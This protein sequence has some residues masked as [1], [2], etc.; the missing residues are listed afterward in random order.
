MRKDGTKVKG[1]D[2]MHKIM[3]HLM[4]NRCDAEVCT[5][6]SFDV[7]KL[8]KYI[9]DKN[10]Q[11]DYKITPFHTIITAL[12][13]TIYNR[14]LL[15]RFIA[16]KHYYD[17]NDVTFS[18]VAK[19]KFADNAEERLLILKVNEGMNLDD[20]SSKIYKDVSKTRKE[21]T[22]DMDHTLDIVTNGPRFIT[23]FIMWAFR[24]MDFYGLIPTSI[25]S[26]D[27]NYT[28]VLI[29]NLGSIKAPACYHHLNNYGTNSI[30]VTVGE[31]HK[32]YLLDKNGKAK[33][34]DMVDISFTLDERIAD[35]FYF[36]KSIKVFKKVIENPTLLND[37]LSE[38][39]NYEEEK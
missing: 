15:N 25:T 8:M 11:L 14:P 9:E 16:G 22:N 28:T 21:G 4:N 17:R 19:N 34:K 37:K 6:Q 20:V 30:M 12:A 39:V 32:E 10:K 5:I 7:T 38:V 18:F 26:T 27:P 31:I 35:G 2:S 1:L 29:S 13:K 33:E 24:K 3:P 23:S 36:S